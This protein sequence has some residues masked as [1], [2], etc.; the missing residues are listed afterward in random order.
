[1]IIYPGNSANKTFCVGNKKGSYEP[2]L[3]ISITIKLSYSLLDV[4]NRQ[5]YL[6]I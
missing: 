5:F 2:F 6:H 4:V 3:I 1:M